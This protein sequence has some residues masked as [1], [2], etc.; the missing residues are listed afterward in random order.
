[1]TTVNLA[2]LYAPPNEMIV[3]AVLDHLLPFHLSYLKA[4]TFFCLASGS[5]EGLDASPRGGAAGFVHALDHK[6]VAFA[7]WPGNNRIASLSNLQQDDR[8]GMLFLFPGLD[9]FMRINGH[10]VISTN[11]P[12]LQSL[13]EGERLPKTAVVVKIDE[14]L[15]HC[16][17]A[18]KRAKLWHPDAKLDRKTLPSPGDMVAAITGADS[19]TAKAID[20]GYDTAMRG[21]LY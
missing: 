4:A 20:E 15:F 12:L 10:A 3:K 19:G 6:T 5:A 1:M 21:Q 14:V 18:I 8:I 11:A 7:D 9:I 2:E 13:A 17:K 16:G